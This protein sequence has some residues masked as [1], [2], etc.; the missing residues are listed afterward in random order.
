MKLKITYEDNQFKINSEAIIEQNFTDFLMKMCNIF[1]KF[2]HYFDLS[3]FELLMSTNDEK[4]YN[5]KPNSRF[6]YFA[7]YDNKEKEILFSHPINYLK[8][9]NFCFYKLFGNYGLMESHIPLSDIYNQRTFFLKIKLHKNTRLINY[10]SSLKVD[11]LDISEDNFQHLINHSMASNRLDLTTDI[12]HFYLTKYNKNYDLE[13]S[14]LENEF[15]FNYLKN[16]LILKE[17]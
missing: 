16:K 15:L 5:K 1:L 13:M 11:E 7:Y 10:K 6:Y 2:E 9:V 4:L 3:S 8:N 12:I 17:F 14:F